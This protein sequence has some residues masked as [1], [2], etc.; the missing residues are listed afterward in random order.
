[1]RSTRG[2]KHL[3]GWMMMTGLLILLYGT[4]AGTCWADGTI[5]VVTDPEGAKVT[6][7]TDEEGITPC[8]LQVP[9]GKRK[10]KIKLRAF[11]GA[12]K[13]VEVKDGETTEVNIKL[14]PIPTT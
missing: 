13:S 4:F 12:N 10:L 7:D 2:W 3:A 5:N 14:V 6:V 9:A 8:T 11:I 1:M